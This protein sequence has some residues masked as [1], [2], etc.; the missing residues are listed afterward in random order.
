MGTTL[1]DESQAHVESTCQFLCQGL[2][3]QIALALRLGDGLFVEV[4]GAIVAPGNPSALRL[5]QRDLV[6]AVRGAEV[7][8]AAQF[9][10]VGGHLLH[11]SFSARP[12][13]R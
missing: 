1:L 4:S 5:N 9:G 13:K 7:R 8:P 10:L 11:Q 12:W 6:L 3:G 2:L